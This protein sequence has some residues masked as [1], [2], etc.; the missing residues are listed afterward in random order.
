MC[1]CVYLN[2]SA[3]NLSAILSAVLVATTDG[4]GIGDGKAMMSNM[5]D[6]LAS[7]LLCYP[8]SWGLNNV[9]FKLI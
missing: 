9:A 5:S 7:V 4:M 1:V 3:L 6:S 2:A 8:I